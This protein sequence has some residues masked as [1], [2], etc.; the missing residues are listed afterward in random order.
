MAVGWSHKYKEL[1]ADFGAEHLVF[2]GNSAEF[3]DQLDILLSSKENHQ[4]ISDQFQ[5]IS[6]QQTEKL[7]D[8]F[9][10]LAQHIKNSL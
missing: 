9:D 8:L 2:N 10:Q 1:L 5:Q 3:L 6:Q 7:C 4:T